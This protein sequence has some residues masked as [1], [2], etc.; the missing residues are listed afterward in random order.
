MSYPFKKSKSHGFKISLIGLGVLAIATPGI[1]LAQEG[2]SIKTSDG[3][4]LKLNICGAPPQQ[5]GK[6]IPN[7]PSKL[8]VLPQIKNEPLLYT[9][10]GASRLW[11]PVGSSNS[12]NI[13]LSDD[14]FQRD[15][16][17]RV[18]NPFSN[19]I[20]TTV[21]RGLISCDSRQINIS[22]G[23]QYNANNQPVAR[24]VTLNQ[25]ID[26]RELILDKYCKK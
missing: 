13:F 16:Y 20:R 22:N 6:P 11:I 3:R 21:G 9:S 18:E 25:I 19:D 4:I 23:D 12:R 14:S 15:P 5:T 7:S 1:L 10:S 24:N 8:P 17:V 2:C 26:A